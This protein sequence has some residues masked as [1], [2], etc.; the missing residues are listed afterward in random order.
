MKLLLG[1]PTANDMTKPFLSSLG[2]LTLPEDC[3]Q[4]ER[5]V[6][7]GNYV[8]AQREMIVR[9]AI[10][11]GF[12]YVVMIDDDI[13]VPPHAL[14]TLI[15]I[16]QADEQTAV[17]GALY[18]SRDGKKPMAVDNWHSASTSTAAIPAFTS[19]ST[20]P[21]SGVGFGC[22]LIDVAKA[23]ELERPFFSPQIFIERA[24]RQVRL[25]N[26]DYRFCE[27][28]TEAGYRVRLA[29]N[30]RCGHYERKTD[31]VMPVAW[32]ADALT[33][34]QRMIVVESGKERLVAFN[35]GIAVASERHE[36]A[37]VDYL[38]TGER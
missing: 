11:G 23:A 14:N 36:V 9:E 1:I 2:G 19:S 37:S 3:V 17:V 15:A 12:D 35:A 30:V 16:A 38:F 34:M 32:E 7:V 33:G 22:V 27:R 29:A 10:E 31:T 6:Y 28:M 5:T 21:V 8:P 20:S 24:S 4:F 26:E 18:Y 25:C 13:V